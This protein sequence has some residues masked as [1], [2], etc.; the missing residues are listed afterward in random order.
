MV[1]DMK[2]RVV[3]CF[4]REAFESICDEQELSVVTRRTFSKLKATVTTASKAWL[5]GPSSSVW[6]TQTRG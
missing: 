5:K 1:T 2:N 4:L 3:N 6:P